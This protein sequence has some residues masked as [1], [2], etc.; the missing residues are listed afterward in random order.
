M[1]IEIKIKAIGNKIFD[2]F[3]YNK[4]NLN[5]NAIILRR[6]EEIKLKLLNMEYLSDFEIDDIS[7]GEDD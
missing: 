6:L 2:S 3:E 5:E 7:E 4:S 1:V